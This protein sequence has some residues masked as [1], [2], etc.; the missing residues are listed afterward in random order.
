MLVKG[1]K[2]FWPST[3]INKT[4][5]SNDIY[6]SNHFFAMPVSAW[7]LCHC[8]LINYSVV[9]INA[10]KFFYLF[11][12]ETV[13]YPRRLTTRLWFDQ[14]LPS[15]NY[16]NN[17]YTWYFS[18]KLEWCKVQKIHLIPTLLVTY[19]MIV[20]LLPKVQRACIRKLLI[21]MVRSYHISIIS[22]ESWFVFHFFMTN[23]LPKLIGDIN[24]GLGAL[25]TCITYVLTI[26]FDYEFIQ[27]CRHVYQS[28]ICCVIDF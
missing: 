8:A 3:P 19:S 4:A 12:I 21:S 23:Y 20:R 27:V 28:G 22:L 17:K 16:E 6:Q 24:R 26:T 25:F 2:M 14:S 15:Y 11:D 7:R 9:C 18:W 13:T 10:I 1:H 5:K